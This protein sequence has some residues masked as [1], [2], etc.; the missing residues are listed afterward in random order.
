MTP[1]SEAFDGHQNSVEF[2]SS[3]GCLQESA[4][5]AASDCRGGAG[6]TSSLTS[7]QSNADAPEFNARAG[8]RARTEKS[9]RHG[10]AQPICILLLLGKYTVPTL[11]RLPL[12]LNINLQS[13]LILVIIKRNKRDA[14]DQWLDLRAFKC[15]RGSNLDLRLVRRWCRLAV[16]ILTQKEGLSV[17]VAVFKHTRIQRLSA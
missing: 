1:M 8:S 9:D 14:I 7:G 5:A 10:A 16:V 12:L 17:I 4:W 6:A 15:C 13:L 11:S 3:R 2:R